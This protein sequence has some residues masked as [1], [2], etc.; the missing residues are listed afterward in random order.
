MFPFIDKY[1]F[2]NPCATQCFYYQFQM[3]STF[4][5]IPPNI[6]IASYWHYGFSHTAFIVGISEFLC[7]S[8]LQEEIMWNMSLTFYLSCLLTFIFNLLYGIDS[9]FF[10]WN[11][12][13]FIFHYKQFLSWLDHDFLVWLTSTSLVF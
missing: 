11:V 2:Y 3:E 10:P 1:W 7:F 9:I 6:L 12:L 5:T 13:A 4:K 8:L